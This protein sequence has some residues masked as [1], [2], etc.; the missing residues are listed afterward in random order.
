MSCANA[1]TIGALNGNVQVLLDNYN[2]NIIESGNNLCGIGVLN[3]G[4]GCISASNGTMTCDIR[5]K[6]IVCLGS[7][8]G[9]LDCMVENSNTT[10]YCEGNSVVGIGDLNGR[11]D[12]KVRDASLNMRILA[13]EILDIGSKSGRL[14]IVDCR[15]NIR[16][17]E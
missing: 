14:E 5:G 2:V 16:M 9:A 7:D 17:N 15:R 4:E 12:I 10:F 3:N 11:G 13:E 1:V 8:Y 6:N